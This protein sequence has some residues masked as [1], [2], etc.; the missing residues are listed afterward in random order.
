MTAIMPLQ[1][2]E[3]SRSGSGSAATTACL[4]LVLARAAIVVGARAMLLLLLA[5]AATACIS[6]G[7]ALLHV[8]ATGIATK[9]FIGGDAIARS[10]LDFQLDDFVPMLICSITL[11]NRK[12]FTQAATRIRRRSYGNRSF[13]R[14]FWIR[15]IHCNL[16][17]AEPVKDEPRIR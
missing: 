10:K 7:F 1:K 9:R 8:A 15:I 5:K 13:R 4:R 11:G 17:K 12:E 6:T 14:I 16:R 2:N 3:T